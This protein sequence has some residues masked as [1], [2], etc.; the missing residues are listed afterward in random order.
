MTT[1]KDAYRYLKSRAPTSVMLQRIEN[2][3]SNGTPDVFFRT[4]DSEGWIENKVGI[5][6]GGEPGKRL[7]RVPRSKLRPAQAAWLTRYRALGGE[8]FI[9]LY[10]STAVNFLIPFSV[11]AWEAL[12]TSRLESWWE[13]QSIKREDTF[14]GD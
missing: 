9:F 7:L 1:E 2:S 13:E 3:V 8:G 10:A 14:Y 12:G 5:L 4:L 11:M 6:G